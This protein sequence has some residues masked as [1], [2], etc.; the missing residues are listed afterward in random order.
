MMTGDSNLTDIFESLEEN[1][2]DDDYFGVS[3]IGLT[4]I[5]IVIFCI[6]YS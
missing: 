6:P 3:Q 4:L 1:Y 5:L 2:D